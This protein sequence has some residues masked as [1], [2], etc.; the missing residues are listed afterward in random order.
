MMLIDH[1][2]AALAPGIAALRAGAS[3]NDLHDMVD[4]AFLLYGLPGAERGHELFPALAA[5]QQ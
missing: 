4:L 2:A 1:G 3:W 5:W